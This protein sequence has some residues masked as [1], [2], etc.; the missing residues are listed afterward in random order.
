MFLLETLGEDSLPRL[1]HLLETAYIFGS[2]SFP[3]FAK[4]SAASSN[5]S[6]VLTPAPLV[7]SAD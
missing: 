5:L 2:W 4:H 6:L 1:F 7:I 3:L